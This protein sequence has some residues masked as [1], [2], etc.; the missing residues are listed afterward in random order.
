LGYIARG[1]PVERKE[2]VKRKGREGK[3]REKEGRKGEREG[4]EG[5]KDSFHPFDFLGFSKK[6]QG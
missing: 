5:K 6:R 4:K 1:E 3:E 2:E